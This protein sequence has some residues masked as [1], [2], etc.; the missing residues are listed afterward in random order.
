LFLDDSPALRVNLSVDWL[1]PPG[2][3]ILKDLDV[4]ELTHVS[5][6]EER[7]PRWNAFMLP[8]HINLLISS[9]KVPACTLSLWMLTYTRQIQYQAKKS[10]VG[11]FNTQPLKSILKFEAIKG[12]RK[13]AEL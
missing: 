3:Q 9:C 5:A 11:Y 8:P 1:N 12:I 6:K 7:N 13:N 10:W 2:I 4:S